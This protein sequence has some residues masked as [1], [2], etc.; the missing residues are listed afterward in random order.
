[1]KTKARLFPQHYLNDHRWKGLRPTIAWGSTYFHLSTHFVHFCFTLATQKTDLPFVAQAALLYS[2]WKRSSLCDDRYSVY[3]TTSPFA[4]LKNLA[5]CHTNGQIW[6]QLMWYLIYITHIL[7]ASLNLGVLM[8]LCPAVSRINY[9]TNHQ[10]SGHRGT[11]LINVTLKTT[12]I[13]PLITI[14][15]S[16]VCLIS[17][18]ESYLIRPDLNAVRLSV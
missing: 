18:S 2:S 13:P 15:F 10:W 3:L 8:V 6:H 1:M 9:I 17:E 12:T 5:F 7:T 4:A 14:T 11:P 16:H